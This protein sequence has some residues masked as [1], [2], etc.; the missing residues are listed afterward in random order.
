MK[1]K[2][3]ELEKNLLSTSSAVFMEN[4]NKTIP[5]SFPKATS[6]VLKQ[7]QIDCPNLFK[8][9]DIWSI[10]KHRKRF[11]DWFSSQQKLS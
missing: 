10:D 4:Y 9:K 5:K 2:N 11:M 6:E 3:D 7:F 1:Y 8:K